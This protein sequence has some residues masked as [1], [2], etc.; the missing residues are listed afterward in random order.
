[1]LARLVH[2]MPTE[3]IAPKISFALVGIE[4]E[5][6]PARTSGNLVEHQP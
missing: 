4:R 1:M 3:D 6:A 5:A 2:C